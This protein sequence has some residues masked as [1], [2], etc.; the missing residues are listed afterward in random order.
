MKLNTPLVDKTQQI[1]AQRTTTHRGTNI[2]DVPPRYL[3]LELKMAARSP[4][5]PN[6]AGPPLGEATPP[7]AA[8]PARS[9]AQA[10][11]RHFVEVK[12]R[13]G[14]LGEAPARGFAW[15]PT[16]GVGMSH[17]L[18]RPARFGSSQGTRLQLGKERCQLYMARIRLATCFCR[19]VA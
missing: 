6:S 12:V 13:R 2:T 14:A 4:G 11:G 8:L 7:R 10:N 5:A 3:Q 1:R 17:P 16:S 15:H 19:R 9:Q 18:L